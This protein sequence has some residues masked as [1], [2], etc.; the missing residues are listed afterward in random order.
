MTA[1]DDVAENPARLVG[2]SAGH[3]RW[4][5][6]GSTSTTRHADVCRPGGALGRQL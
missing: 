6:L 1:L 4:A 5:G 3:D 2:S